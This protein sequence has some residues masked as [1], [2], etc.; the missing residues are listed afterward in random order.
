MWDPSPLGSS[1]LRHLSITHQRQVPMIKPTP[2]HD[3]SD[4]SAQRC[5]SVSWSYSCSCPALW[6]T[7]SYRAISLCRRFQKSQNRCRS[8]GTPRWP[9]SPSSNWSPSC[10]GASEPETE[11]KKTKMNKTGADFYLIWNKSTKKK[12][13]FYSSPVCCRTAPSPSGRVQGLWSG[14]SRSG[15]DW[16]NFLLQ[17]QKKKKKK[18][19]NRGFFFLLLQKRQENL[20]SFLKF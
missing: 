10:P 14:T 19:V 12:L 11:Q 17:G 7:H 4:I 15:F 2:L 16:E 18:F 8:S 3:R 6:Q 5:Q 20:S 1:L 9:R 13:Q